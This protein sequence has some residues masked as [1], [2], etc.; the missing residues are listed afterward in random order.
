[1]KATSLLHPPSSTTTIFT[2]NN[3]FGGHFT[4][5]DGKEA[6]VDL[7]LIQTSSFIM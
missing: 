7:V 6:R 2:E 5:M 4:V 1:M 3:F